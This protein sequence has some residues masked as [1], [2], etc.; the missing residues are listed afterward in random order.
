MSSTPMGRSRP[1][2]P[3]AAVLVAVVVFGL[4]LGAVSAP[5]PRLAH[6]EGEARIVI[7]PGQPGATG[8]AVTLAVDGLPANRAFN[9]YELT[10]KFDPAVTRVLAVEAAGNWDINLVPPLIDPVAGTVRITAITLTPSCGTGCALA[11]IMFVGAGSG[12]A[13]ALSST[14]VTLAAGGFEVPVT[15]PA[16]VTVVVPAGDGGAALP[17]RAFAPALASDGTR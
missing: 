6:A 17:F 10:L 7:T 14:G 16:P 5:A 9:G 2:G 1:A 3:V 15:P 11:T 13:F 4:V 8:T 12:G